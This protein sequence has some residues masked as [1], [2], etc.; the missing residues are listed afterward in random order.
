[1]KY[2]FCLRY[3]GILSYS[4]CIGVQYTSVCAWNLSTV[5]LSLALYVVCVC[6]THMDKQN[7]LSRQSDE[8]NRCQERES[9]MSDTSRI[10]RQFEAF[11]CCK[12]FEWPRFK[13]R[14]NSYLYL[15]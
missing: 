1:M 14:G 6:Y 10:L 7:A 8:V 13:L 4:L 15:S 5:K 9:K 11:I 3:A 2:L 12:M